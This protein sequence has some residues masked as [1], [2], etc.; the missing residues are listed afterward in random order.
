MPE[1]PE[2]ETIRRQLQSRIVGKTIKAVE[3][4]YPK[5]V[6][7]MRAADFVRTLVGRKVREVGRQ[8]KLILIRLSGEE[9]LVVHLK[10]TGR[11]LLQ[12]SGHPEPRRHGRG[13][14]SHTNKSTEVIL[15]F[16]DGTVLRYDDLRRFGYMRL[17]TDAE[18]EAALSGFG[19]EPFTKN[20]TYANFLAAIGQRKVAIKTA[21]LDQKKIAGIG[22]I[23]ADEVCFCAKVLPMRTVASL[24]DS[25]KKKIFLCIPRILKEAIKHRGTTFRD[26]R[27]SDGR[28]GNY[29]D[30]L[31]VF[32]REGEKCGRCGGIVKKIKS[33]GRGTHFCAGC[34]R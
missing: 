27:D 2:V 31:Q 13:A 29:T 3:V 30:F 24:T 17:A 26:Y 25:E 7:K 20:F 18:V 21:L 6:H 32:D 23:Y 34:Q 5:V 22:N 19:I 9:T 15:I 12:S 14:G 4:L 16:T 28:R 11:L 10:M 1:L 8:G 33:G